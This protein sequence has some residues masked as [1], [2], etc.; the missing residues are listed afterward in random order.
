MGLSMRSMLL[1]GG[2]GRRRIDRASTRAQ[3]R[4]TAGREC[5][6]PNWNAQLVRPAS[7][8]APARAALAGNPSDGYG[9]RTLA[10][11]LP[12]LGGRVEVFEADGV[13]LGSLRLSSTAELHIAIAAGREPALMA[14]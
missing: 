4:S 3:V 10:L 1:T 7:A 12:Q 13:E 11:A 9:G 6:R 2:P 14:A 8:S 5:A